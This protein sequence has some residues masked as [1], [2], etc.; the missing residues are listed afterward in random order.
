MSVCA[1][2][3]TSGK[4]TRV[5]QVADQLNTLGIYSTVRHPLYLGNF[6][7][8]FA[9]ALLTANYWFVCVFILIYW[10]YYER[11]AM[12]EK[13]FLRRKFGSKYLHWAD[14]VPAFIP[15]ILLF[16]KPALRFS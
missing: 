2:E 15:N 14:A 7:S 4:N 16:K 10:L 12:A 3:N 1:P 5:G 9:I 13:Q 8:W 11:I 6:I